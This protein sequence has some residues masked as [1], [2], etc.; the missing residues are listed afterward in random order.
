MR[1]QNL[2]FI[3]SDQHDP[4]YL[5][6]AGHPIIRTPN[7]DRL[8]ASGTRFTRASTP[9]PICVPARASLATGRY[10][11][12]V[13][14]WDNAIAYD[15]SIPSW[16]HRL[17]AEGH[18]VAAIGKLHYRSDADDNGF[19]EKI[20]TMNVV[21]GVGD[22]LGWLRRHRSERGAARQYAE[23]A[24]RGE[25]TYTQYDRRVARQ[26]CE[27]L[28]RRAGEPGG[29]PWVLF[30]GFV[31]PHL[32]LIAP[33]EFYDLY[34]G[35]ALPEPRLQAPEQRAR[36]PWL[37]ELTKV[38]P[39]DKYFT[40][41][42]RKVAIT[43]YHGMVSLLD[44]HVG[45]LLQALAASGL[46]ASTRVVYTSDHGEVLGN[47]G[48]WGK[49]CMYEESVSVP[50]IITGEGVPAGATAGSETSLV[51]CYPTILDA[52][53]MAQSAAERRELPGRSLF[54]LIARPDE[55]RVGFSEYHAVGAMSGCF[56]VRRGRWKY[57]HYV[58][59]PPQLFDLQADPIEAHDLGEDPSYERERRMMEGELRKI[60][61]P[62]AASAQ[63]FADQDARIAAH[64]GVEAVRAIGD[65]GHTPT[66]GE[67]PHFA[68]TPEA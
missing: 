63:A 17:I 2:L 13:R 39:Y 10:V 46:A 29:K 48:I 32:P 53:G 26:A 66:P 30:V 5:G 11:H 3:F 6:A 24:G 36:H 47:H 55:T 23:M 56:M 68:K 51:D 57:V 58:G 19:S 16:G 22:R 35:E 67:D 38:I 12:R 54:D 37:D 14:M 60:V 65:F 15:G 8:A 1:P 44:H 62:E 34:A 52:L 25:S 20:D 59:L 7:L 18:R 27:W 42:R 64:G 33:P 50:L 4:S 49:C 21:E 40:A 28:D 43:A 9:C 41:E 31:M 61:D 45:M